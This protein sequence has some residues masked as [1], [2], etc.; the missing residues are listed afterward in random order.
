MDGTVAEEISYQPLLLL[1]FMA[2]LLYKFKFS[3]TYSSHNS[4]ACAEI[5]FSSF[6]S[7][8]YFSRLCSVLLAIV[9][10]LNKDSSREYLNNHRVIDHVQQFQFRESVIC[11]RSN[12]IRFNCFG[13]DRFVSGFTAALAVT[14]LRNLI[15][16]VKIACDV[17]NR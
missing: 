5:A 2:S 9:Q 8:L 1:P 4:E 16:N 15:C 14:I 17:P 7:D 11:K 6:I 3:R 13:N 12:C 10:S